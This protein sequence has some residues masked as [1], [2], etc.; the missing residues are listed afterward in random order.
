V[1]GKIIDRQNLG[2]SVLGNLLLILRISQVG[3]GGFGSG[4]ISELSP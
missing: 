2:E 1:S 3:K 4:I